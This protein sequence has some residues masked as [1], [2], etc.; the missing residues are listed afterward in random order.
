MSSNKNFTVTRVPDKDWY[1]ILETLSLD[2][3]FS[4][5]IREEVWTAIENM[6]DYTWAWVVVI[7]GHKR[8]SVKIFNRKET[9]RAYVKRATPHL[10]K[11]TQVLCIKAEYMSYRKL[12][13]KPSIPV[14]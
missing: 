6:E 3:S 14:Y 1:N 12:V 7:I 5:Q 11:S 2:K 9:A 10:P 4:F 8:S 13:S